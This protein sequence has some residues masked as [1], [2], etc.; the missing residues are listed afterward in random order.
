MTIDSMV[1]DA[2]CHAAELLDSRK[3]N[4]FEMTTIPTSGFALGTRQYVSYMSVRRWSLYAPGMW[5]TNYGGLAYSDDDGQTWT[6]DDYLHWDNIFGL[7]QFQVAAMVPQGDYVYLFGTPN[8]RL[9]SIGLARVPKTEILNK[10]AYEYWRDGTWTP[11]E[12]WKIPPN[13]PGTE[14]S[15]SRIVPGMAGELSVRYDENAQLWQMSYLDVSKNAIELR[16]AVRPQGVWSSP[17]TLINTMDY[18]ASYGGFLHPWSTDKDLYFT[19]SE[20]GPYNVFLMHAGLSS[21]NK[22]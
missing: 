13:S 17:S 8:G 12:E 16:E 18:P 3:I 19:I 11:T 6:K 15:A 14:T 21:G 22:H 4:N 10:S 1:S 20:W 2:P 5:W 7:G 9:G